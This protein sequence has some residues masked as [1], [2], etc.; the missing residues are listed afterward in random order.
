MQKITIEVLVNKSLAEVW[1]L[2]TNPKHIT[3]WNHASDDWHSPKAENDLKPGGKFCFRMEAKDDSMGF[4]FNGVYSEVLVNEKIAYNIEGGRSVEIFFS[5]EG[6]QSKIVEV[7]E[8][9]SE[10][11][12]EMQ[13]NG[14]QSI[15]NNFKKY[16][17]SQA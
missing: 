16:A 8:A 17:E 1:E 4:D 12:I 5:Q 11:P 3:Q 15:L 2:W 10:N 14:W 9:E 13:K 6:D 7:F